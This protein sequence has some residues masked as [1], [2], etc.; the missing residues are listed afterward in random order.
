MVGP[1][2]FGRR[3]FLQ[4]ASMGF[5]TLALAYL[6]DRECR[7]VRA[8][9]PTRPDRIDLHLRPVTFPPGPGR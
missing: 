6:L 9:S 5:G 1:G 7:S 3:A 2:A 8:E 4:D